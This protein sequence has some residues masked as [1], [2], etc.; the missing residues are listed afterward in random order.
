MDLKMDGSL[1]PKSNIP[2]SLT[3]KGYTQTRNHSFG[4]VNDSS[5]SVIQQGI[6]SHISQV[7]LNG[8]LIPADRF[9]ENDGTMASFMQILVFCNETVT[10]DRND[11]KPDLENALLDFAAR[12]GFHKKLFDKI[13]PKIAETKVEGNPRIASTIIGLNGR[14]RL[15][16]KDEPMRLLGRCDKILFKG[17]AVPLTVNMHAKVCNVS[18]WMI[19]NNLQVVMLALKDM[20]QLPLKLDSVFQSSGLTLVGM[21]GLRDFN[22]D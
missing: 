15:V 5:R 9:Y 1:T 17:K 13:V 14:Y 2:K 18:Q 11:K 8:K 16:I 21:I 20:D 3:L 4:F 7:Y 12:R 6:A 19:H 10:D 22:T